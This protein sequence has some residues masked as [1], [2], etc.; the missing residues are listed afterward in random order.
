MTFVRRH[1]PVAFAAVFAGWVYHAW[2]APGLVMGDDFFRFSDQVLR[3]DFPWMR[4][5]DSTFAFGLSTAT[6]A[7]EYPLWSIA[8]LLARAGL[9]F[10]VS[11]RVVWLWPL[12]ILLVAAPYALAYRLTHSAWASTLGGAVFAVNTWTVALVQR[13]H[14]SS[15]V[16]Y[17]LMPLAALACHAW[18]RRCDLQRSVV[19]AA[20]LTVEVMYDLRYAYMAVGICAVISAAWVVSAR[21]ARLGPRALSLARGALMAAASSLVFNSYW[22]I[23]QL[24]SPASLPAGYATLASFVAGSSSESLAHAAA[25]FMPYY[26]Y[27]EGSDPF[28][29]YPVEPAFF[30]LPGL[31]LISLVAARRSRYALPFAI[32]ALAGIVITAGP[33]PP[34][35]PVVAWTF[36]HVPGMSFFRDISKFNALV[37][38]AYSAAIALGFAWFERR[39]RSGSGVHAKRLV[40]AAALVLV[41][42]Y[43]A[44]MHDAFNPFRF[45]NFATTTLSPDDVAAQQFIDDQPGAFATLLYPT[46]RPEIVATE[47]HPLVSASYWLEFTQPDQGAGDL[48]APD[49]TLQD[50]MSSPLLPA[51]LAEAGV[52]YVLLIDDRRGDVYTPSQFDVQYAQSLQFLQ[53]LPWLHESQQFGRYVFFAITPRGFPSGVFPS[54]PL[55]PLAIPD[56]ASQLAAFAGTPIWRSGP[57]IVTHAPEWIGM[58]IA[59]IAPSRIEAIVAPNSGAR[60]VTAFGVAAPADADVYLHAHVDPASANPIAEDPFTSESEL[61]P[62]APSNAQRT[63]DVATEVE[64]DDPSI[65]S[66]P[67]TSSVPG[68]SWLGL[69]NDRAVLHIVDLSDVPLDARVTLTLASPDALDRTV[70]VA[71]GKP[72]EIYTVPGSTAATNSDVRV[73]NTFSFA[74]T[75]EPGDNDI[76]LQ[77]SGGAKPGFKLLLRDDV[78]VEASLIQYVEARTQPLPVTIRLAGDTLHLEATT[79][80]LSPGFHEAAWQMLTSAPAPVAERP[81]LTIGYAA[82]PRPLSL[83]VSLDFSRTSDG[84][85]YQAL[86]ALPSA[87]RRQS[88]DVFDVLQAALDTDW[89]NRLASATPSY[90]EQ[91]G[92]VGPE[93][94]DFDLDGVQ[95]L[96]LAPA[97]TLPGD[98]DAE[99]FDARI[100]LQAPFAQKTVVA[101]TQPV[102]LRGETIKTA[103]APVRVTKTGDTIAV[104]PSSAQEVDIRIPT[105]AWPQARTLVF[106]LGI[107]ADAYAPVVTLGFTRG[108]GTG[109]DVVAAAA[110]PLLTDPDAPMPTAWV[111]DVDDPSSDALHWRRYAIDLPAVE[112]YRLPNSGAGYALASLRLQLVPVSATATTPLEVEVQSPELVGPQLANDGSLEAPAYALDDGPMKTLMWHED[113][114]GGLTAID[115]RVALSEGSHRIRLAVPASLDVDGA[116]V[117]RSNRSDYVPDVEMGERTCSPVEYEARMRTFGPP[118]LGL[119][120][121]PQAY[122][123]GWRVADHP[124]ARDDLTGNVV[125]DWWRLRNDFVPDT[126]HVAADGVFN[127][128]VVLRNSSRYVLLYVPAVTSDLSAIVWLLASSTLVAVA[129]RRRPKRR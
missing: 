31:A 67:F 113:P 119:L 46:Q 68:A 94:S 24:V 21:R 62:V 28:R 34:F 53:S 112:A 27:I 22:L 75:L 44:L 55:S 123:P 15:L 52:R 85:T 129:L 29:A 57:A 5:W 102:D 23:P 50:R 121:F 39:L 99:L 73:G 98:F 58:Q 127:G 110:R 106:E 88:I 76:S 49:A 95:L 120:L 3:S 115:S 18:L 91:N 109:E 16:A 100:D 77:V 26:H 48:F 40:P 89:R 69:L 14:I 83:A 10:E 4:A 107:R 35:G 11:E 101:Q 1:W 54:M 43:V 20:I 38:F 87:L 33:S 78:A 2:L 72:T 116:I 122:A 56:D 118:S 86:V 92:R 25:L 60:S 117:A 93:A 125:L 41:G 37:A 30:A 104:M 97:S 79:A 47:L 36:L 17:A 105:P 70:T 103:A 19:F 42:A 59:G 66:A 13:G 45:S 51:L 63:P 82:P 6:Q 74:C 126:S 80:G 65:I 64:I 128:W 12:L 71:P 61:M 7:P 90:Y 96:M 9:G 108:R 114:D 81:L 124:S 111:A 32:V 8:G 84:R